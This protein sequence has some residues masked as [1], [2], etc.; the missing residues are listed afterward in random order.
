VFIFAEVLVLLHGRAR[1][2]VEIKTE[3]V[4]DDAEG[5]IE[6]WVAEE[7]RWAGMVGDVGFISFDQGYPAVASRFRPSRGAALQPHHRR[8][9]ARA[10][11][12]K[13]T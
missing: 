12:G 9:L 5:G 6:V 11:G 8:V 7:V 10:G 13:R 3:S 1:V 4:T 2:F